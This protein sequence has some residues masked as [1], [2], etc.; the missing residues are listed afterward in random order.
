MTADVA[1]VAKNL[2]KQF[3]LDARARRAI[4]ASRSRS[5]PRRDASRCKEP[6]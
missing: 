6:L 3:L 2:G 1:T 5:I 4:A